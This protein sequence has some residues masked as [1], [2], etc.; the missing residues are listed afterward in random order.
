MPITK[1]PS[2]V[3]DQIAAGEVI[4]RPA[5][6]AKELIENSLDAGARNIQVDIEQ[7]GIRLIRVRDD[8]QGLAGEDLPAAFATHATS[9]IEQIDDLE[10]PSYPWLSR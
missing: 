2:Q 8:G 10:R 4:E 7:G 5:S 9:K 1:L 3:I 6:V